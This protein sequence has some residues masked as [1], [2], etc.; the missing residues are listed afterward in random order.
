[1]GHRI[2]RCLLVP[3][4]R[5]LLPATGRRRQPSV[6]AREIPSVTRY[7]HSRTARRPW[8]RPVRG[9][10]TPLARP[11]LVAHEQREVERRRQTRRRTLR[12]AVHGVDIRP[13]MVHVHA[14]AV[15]A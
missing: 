2:A 10:D 12:I 15:T 1:M 11:Y 7:L 4:L 8:E 3:L 13:H 14:V 5:L 6:A 9:E